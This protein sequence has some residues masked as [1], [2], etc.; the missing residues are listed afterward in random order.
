MRY[1]PLIESSLALT[2]DDFQLE[3]FLEKNVKWPIKNVKWPIKNIKWPSSVW[4]IMTLAKKGQSIKKQL[5][6]LKQ[7]DTTAVWKSSDHVFHCEQWKHK[8]WITYQ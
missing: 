5:E 3:G 1:T 7:Q 8:K 2:V 6:R 4:S